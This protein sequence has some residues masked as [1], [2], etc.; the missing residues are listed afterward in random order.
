MTARAIARGL[1]TFVVPPALYNR[2]GGRTLS[3][4]YCYS[5]YLRHVAM[6]HA[7]GLPTDGKTVAEIGPGESIGTGLAALIAGAEQYYGFDIKDY[8]RH[9]DT[10]ALF[11]DIVALFRARAP[12]PGD[13]EFP[14]IK[15]VLATAEFPHGALPEARLGAAL[16]EYR[17][18]KLRTALARGGEAAP[19]K[20]AAPW[21]DATRVRAKSVD[22]IFSQAVMEHIDDLPATFRACRQWL[23]DSGTM[24][25]QIDYKSHGTAPAWNGHWQYSPLAWRCVRGARLYLVNRHPHSAYLRALGDAGFRVAI[26]KRVTRDDG[27]GRAQLRKPYRELSDDDLVTAGAFLAARAA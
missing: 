1:L 25:H 24:S 12:I 16:D 21:F 19:V 22:W 4:R 20:Y 23:A 2:S 10:L 26:E 3:A 14:T 27:I 18:A 6:L 13:G 5:V 11:D 7:A 15:P 8:G 9:P 17:I